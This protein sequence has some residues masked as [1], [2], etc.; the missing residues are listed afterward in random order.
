MGDGVGSAIVSGGFAAGGKGVGLGLTAW[1]LL[2]LT[3]FLCNFLA[4]RAD[5]R[6]ARLDAQE[7]RLS[8][9]LGKRLAHLEQMEARQGQQ[10][11]S[12]RECVEILAAELRQRDPGN[13]KLAEVASLLRQGIGPIA[14]DTPA[15]MQGLLDRMP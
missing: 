1:S 15:D 2:Q 14:T 12:L 7:E 5:A 10:I 3:K 6:Q 9:S 4:G 13:S 8:V 11:A